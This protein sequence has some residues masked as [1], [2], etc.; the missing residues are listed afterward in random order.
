MINE[1]IHWKGYYLAAFNF[2]WLRA[3]FGHF[4]S[5]FWFNVRE[6]GAE[7]SKNKQ[8][9]HQF[10]LS[11]LEESTI[12]IIWW[13]VKFETVLEPW[14]GWEELYYYVHWLIDRLG[15]NAFSNY[16]SLISR[17]PFHL[18]MCF[19]AF[20]Y[21]VLASFP[22]RLLYSLYQLGCF[23]VERDFWIYSDK[24]RICS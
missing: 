17:L 12:F 4:L 19:L 9:F 7:I 15:L 2:P 23:C 6:R 16:F 14:Q 3:L 10:S 18:L 21:P 1:P 8:L 13:L 24:R 22:Y 5:L 20:L 11:T